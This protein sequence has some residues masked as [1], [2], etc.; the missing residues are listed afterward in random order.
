VAAPALV[1]KV[2]TQA[3]E[4]EQIHRLNYATFVEEIPQHAPAASRV[5]IDKFHAQ[6]T[7]IVGLHGA[8]LAAMV[9]VRDQRP[10][11]L[12]A[13]LD[14]LDQYLPAH[15]GLCE[16]RLLAVK[17]A[18]R[19]PRVFWGLMLALGSYCES[20]GYDLAVISGTVRQTKLYRRMNF[21]PFGGLTGSPQAQFQP[22]YVTLAGFQALRRELCRGALVAGE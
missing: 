9:A 14:H 21:V 16:V 8:D 19:R 5:L 3:A 11:S 12:D 13:K 10:F 15:R 18:Y 2:A 6:N 1:F 7:Y 17:P 20:R 4:F 22:M